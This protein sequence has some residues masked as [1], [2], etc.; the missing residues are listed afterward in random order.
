MILPVETKGFSTSHFFGGY[1]TSTTDQELTNFSW[2]ERWLIY[3]SD[4][5]QLV[6]KMMIL[7]N[8]ALQRH[9]PHGT[10]L[11]LRVFELE[12]TVQYTKRH[13][14]MN[15]LR[16]LNLQ[17]IW[18]VWKNEMFLVCRVVETRGESVGSEYV[19]ISLWWSV[20]SLLQGASQVVGG[21]YPSYNIL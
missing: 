12:D 4:H 1:K 17:P 3:P 8:V 2:S 18:A 19:V 14:A 6:G 7:W 15:D 10:L 5:G 16:L 9:A 11:A 20:P 13:Q 21:L